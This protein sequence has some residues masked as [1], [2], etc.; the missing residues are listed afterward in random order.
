MITIM[1]KYNKKIQKTKVETVEFPRV[2]KLTKHK[3]LPLQ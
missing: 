2:I 1:H 3:Y